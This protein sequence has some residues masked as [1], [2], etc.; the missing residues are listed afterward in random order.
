MENWPRATYNNLYKWPESDVEF[1]KKVIIS[2]GYGVANKAFSC[3]QACLRSYTFS[4]E[5]DND[6]HNHHCCT[7][8]KR[9][10]KLKKKRSDRRRGRSPI[11]S[12]GGRCHVPSLLIVKTDASG[13]RVG[14]FMSI[15]SF[16]IVA[17][18]SWRISVSISYW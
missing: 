13:H 14:S 8:L 11:P 4:R 9:L 18:G 17:K 10:S 12:Y 7:K 5:E 1:M 15:A 2:G 3:R 16:T 6:N